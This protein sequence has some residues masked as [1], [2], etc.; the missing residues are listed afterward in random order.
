M[1]HII[2][3]IDQMTKRFGTITALDDVSMRFETGHLYGVIGP[4]GAGGSVSV[5][6]G[7]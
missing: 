6:R 5:I 7:P 1:T 3:N 4:A 2:L